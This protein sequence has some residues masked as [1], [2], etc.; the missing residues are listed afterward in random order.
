M[1]WGSWV[2]AIVVRADLPDA[3]RP[4]AWAPRP[5]G[6]A[7][8]MSDLVLLERHPDPGDIH[9]PAAG[10]HHPGPAAVRGL[11]LRR[12][13]QPTASARYTAAILTIRLRGRPDPRD[14]RGHSSLAMVAGYILGLLV[15]RLSGLYLGMATIAFALFSRS[16]PST[17]ASS[18][19]GADWSLRRAERR[20]TTIH[21]VVIALVVVLALAANERARSGARWTPSGRTRSWP[22]SL[23]IDVNRIPPACLR[24]QRRCSAAT[25]GAHDE[26]AALDRAAGDD[27]LP[28]GR[29]RAHDDHRRRCAV[30]GRG[31]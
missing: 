31:R 6:G 5:Q 18:T 19:G 17:A 21:V 24:R 13:R 26:P 27:R 30:L 25:A 14:R 10:T 23:G 22:S 7:A 12:R 9:Q 3:A 16:S 2:D 29:H 1:N 4:P 8:H 11:L 28:P 20:S 15:A